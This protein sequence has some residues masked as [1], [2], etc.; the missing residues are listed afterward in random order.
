MWRDQS[1]AGSHGKVFGEIL[2]RDRSSSLP[3]TIGVELRVL[4]RV[5]FSAT[6]DFMNQSRA[7]MWVFGFDASD[8]RSRAAGLGDLIAPQ[9]LRGHGEAGLRTT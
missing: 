9:R 6:T 2:P 7:K 3:L 8:A 4:V 5:F 1:P